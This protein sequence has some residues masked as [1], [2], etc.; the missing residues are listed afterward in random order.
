MI[1]VRQPTPTLDPAKEAPERRPILVRKNRPVRWVLT[2]MAVMALFVVA[3]VSAGGYFAYHAARN[4][5]VDLDLLRRKPVFAMTK[6]A[7][8]RN[9]NLEVVSTDE[10]ADTVTARDRNTSLVAA[11]RYD[12]DKRSLAVVGGDPTQA[13]IAPAGQG[14]NSFEMR[15]PDGSMRFGPA[16]AES[17]PDWIPVYRGGTL[18]GTATT[19]LAEGEQNSFTF[20]TKD[21]PIEVLSFYENALK[22][23]GFT[24]NVAITGTD[25]VMLQGEADGGKRTVV[26]TLHSS[27]AGTEGSIVTVEKK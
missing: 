1:D 6:L 23:S 15:G 27:N 2:G 26:I 10:N 13:R 7:V 17:V 18:Q 4:A 14:V 9:P 5:G 22:G 16:A 21:A 20:N 3:L 24:V 19:S 8:A 12:L 11:Y 25:G